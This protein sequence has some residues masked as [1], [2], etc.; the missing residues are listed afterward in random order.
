[1]SSKVNE[2]WMAVV[3]PHVHW[4]EDKKGLSNMTASLHCFEQVVVVV[5]E[6]DKTIERCMPSYRSNCDISG[7]ACS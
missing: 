1:M 6:E 5:V 3:P 4:V 2:V 7:H